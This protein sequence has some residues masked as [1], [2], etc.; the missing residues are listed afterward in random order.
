M[1]FSENRKNKEPR[2]LN[3]YYCEVSMI[4]TNLTRKKIGLTTILYCGKCFEK[5]KKK[6]KLLKRGVDQCQQV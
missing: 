2:L 4:E 1:M 5:P 3:C 6:V